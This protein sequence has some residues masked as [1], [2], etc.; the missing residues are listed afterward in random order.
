[1]RS[2]QQGAHLVG[3]QLS[4]AVATLTK[5]RDSSGFA[6]SSA[7]PTGARASK[8]KNEAMLKA[9]TLPHNSRNVDIS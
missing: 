3:R 8:P 6:D 7:T 1:V 2:S 9:L 4:N 5:G